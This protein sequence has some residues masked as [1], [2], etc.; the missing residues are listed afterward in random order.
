MNKFKYIL[1]LALLMAVPLVS[2]SSDKDKKSDDE[3]G[4]ENKDA[5]TAYVTTSTRSSEFAKQEIAVGSQTMINVKLQ[6]DSHPV[7]EMQECVTQS[8]N[9]PRRGGG[10]L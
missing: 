10:C 4:S 1:G 3:G 8:E 9:N 7:R 5:V 6:E 2:C